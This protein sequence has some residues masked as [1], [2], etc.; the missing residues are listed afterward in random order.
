MMNLLFLIFSI[1]ILVSCDNNDVSEE[2]A[3]AIGDK[4][5]SSAEQKNKSPPAS[6]LI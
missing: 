1:F 2:Q 4:N 5:T 6:Y 3:V